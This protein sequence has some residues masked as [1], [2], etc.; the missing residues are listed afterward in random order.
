MSRQL[1]ELEAILQALINEHRKLLT[2]IDAHQTAM[3]KMDLSK[4]D[5]AAKQQ[6]AARLRISS[7]EAKRQFAVNQLARMS[8]LS[9][10]ITLAR[11]ADV[12]PLRREPLLKLRDELREMMLEIKSRTNVAGRVAGAVLGHLNTVVRLLA[13]AVEQAGLYTKNGVPKVSARIGVMEA[14]G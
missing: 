2:H 8:K 12:N 13:G 7:L 6:E 3:R 5:A 9:G 10:E 4:M 14:V 11:V 1:L